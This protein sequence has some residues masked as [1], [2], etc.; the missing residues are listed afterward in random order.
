MKVSNL[1]PILLGN[2]R[3][4]VYESTEG[5]FDNYLFEASNDYPTVFR[6]FSDREILA[7]TPSSIETNVLKIVLQKEETNV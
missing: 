4:Q 3:I 6:Y 1:I 5:F 2:M 7:L